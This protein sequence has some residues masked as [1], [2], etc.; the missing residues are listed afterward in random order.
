M[1]LFNI[2]G[3]GG[4]GGGG[5][6]RTRGGYYNHRDLRESTECLPNDRDFNIRYSQFIEL[7]KDDYFLNL[8]L[9]YFISILFPA[10]HLPCEI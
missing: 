9:H 3:G 8:S 1:N 4:G 10:K 5:G 2:C 6:S 7:L